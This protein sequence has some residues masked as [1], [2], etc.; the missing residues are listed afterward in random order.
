M[1]TV[2]SYDASLGFRGSAGVAWRDLVAGANMWRI[3]TVLG[4]RD[5]YHQ[6]NRTILGPA[7]S[8]VGLV[9]MVGSLGF[10][11]GSLLST[12][13]RVGYP[14]TAAG[15]IAWFFISGC[16]QGGFTTFVN[17][18]GTM[19]ERTLPV[20]FGLYRYTWRLFVEFCLK[21]SVFAFFAVFSQFNPGL[22]LLYL[23]PMLVLYFCN[24][25]WV[26]LLFGIIGGRARDM[27]QLVN[28]LMLI[29]FLA[30]PVLWPSSALGANAFI[31][32]Y[33]PLS[34]F[35]DIIREPLLGNAPPFGSLV[36]VFAVTI[37][38]WSAAFFVFAR[39]RNNIV[40]WL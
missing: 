14:F 17:S 23:V 39:T 1:E 35:I 11:Y 19:K 2:D 5:F 27:A 40:F 33:N 10:V 26:N 9:I 38:G 3:W 4:W 21:F 22:S 18:A 29:A 15:L 31:S 28:P 34:H 32:T 16:L 25:L 24:G 37:M 30:T 20:S 12:P 8:V 6:T 13:A 7:W 36:L